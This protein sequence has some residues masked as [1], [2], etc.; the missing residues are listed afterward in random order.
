MTGQQIGTMRRREFLAVLAGGDSLAGRGARAAAGDDRDR[1]SASGIARPECRATGDIPQGIG[2]GRFRRGPEHRHRIPVGGRTIRQAA[3]SGRRSGSAKG[4]GDRHAIL[5][6]RRPCRQGRHQNDP[7]R[8]CV[9]GRPGPDRSGREPES[10]RRQ[11]HRRHYLEHGACAKTAGAV[12]RARS[13]CKPLFRARQSDRE[14]RRTLYPGYRSRRRQ[15]RDSDRYSP[16]Q[17]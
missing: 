13:G 11:Y 6:R 9:V 17:Q 7:D 8:V 16:R 1:L 14:P 15:A 2:P 5:D 12:A 10:A 4:S 3:G